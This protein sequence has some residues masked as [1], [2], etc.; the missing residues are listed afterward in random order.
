M[1]PI[2]KRGRR[3]TSQKLDEWASHDF[4]PHSF[5]GKL[6]HLRASPI[7]CAKQPIT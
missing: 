7:C 2:S 3:I 5:V 4:V 6:K 1:V